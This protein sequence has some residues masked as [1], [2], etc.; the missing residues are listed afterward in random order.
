MKF[1]A[2][3][4][5]EYVFEHDIETMQG[6]TRR[7]SRTNT[8]IVKRDGKFYSLYWECGSTEMQDNTYDEQD[9]PEVEKVKKTVIM[10]E[11]VK[12]S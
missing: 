6:E 7:W 3:Q 1:T 8:T 5:E 9:A 4:V 11:W 12:V 10:E 2:E